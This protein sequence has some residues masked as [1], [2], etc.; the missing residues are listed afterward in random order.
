MI[1]IIARTAALSLSACDND[2]SLTGS[3][4]E[5]RANGNPL[6]ACEVA[7][8]FDTGPRNLPTIHPAAAK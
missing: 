6:R 1:L 4:D 3:I 8:A 5:I 7:A 2:L